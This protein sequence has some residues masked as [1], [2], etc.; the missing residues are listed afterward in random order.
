MATFVLSVAASYVISQAIGPPSIRLRQHAYTY[1]NNEAWVGSNGRY[2][3]KHPWEDMPD[4]EVRIVLAQTS[5]LLIMFSGEVWTE[6]WG[7][8]YVRALV[9]TPFAKAPAAAP[10]QTLAYPLGPDYDPSIYNIESSIVLTEWVK[11]E[12]PYPSYLHT[13]T[14]SSNSF[15]FYLPRVSAGAHTVK[16]QWRTDHTHPDEVHWPGFAFVKART[17]NVIALP[18]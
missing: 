10:E 5:H 1:S 8:L 17:L 4:M 2:G 13:R 7:T 15:I 14:H 9:T 11:H 3:G 6:Y 18:E 12:D 16:I